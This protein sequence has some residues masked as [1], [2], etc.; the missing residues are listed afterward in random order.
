[1]ATKEKELHAFLSFIYAQQQLPEYRKDGVD[2]FLPEKIEGIEHNG[3]NE[4][5]D[6][7]STLE[8]LGLIKGEIIPFRRASTQLK[9]LGVRLT[10]EGVNTLEQRLPILRSPQQD[11]SVYQTINFGGIHNAQNVVAGNNNTIY[12]QASS[13]KELE[14]HLQALAQLINQLQAPPK[15][16]EKAKSLFR[17][18]LESNDWAALTS[19]AIK[20]LLASL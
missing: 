13:A 9:V 6:L 19:T 3:L 12:Q 18:I 1:M 14:Q 4:H 10:T 7:F 15:E 5:K 20:A 2:G 8:S 17:K 11:A 16:K